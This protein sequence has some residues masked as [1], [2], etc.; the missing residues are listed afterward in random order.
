MR[1]RRTKV[2]KIS[3]VSHNDRQFVSAGLRG[4]HGISDEPVG[5]EV[6]QHRPPAE[7]GRVHGQPARS[8]QDLTKADLKS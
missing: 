2:P 5:L 7:A 3:D 1:L 8:G 4:D 6:L